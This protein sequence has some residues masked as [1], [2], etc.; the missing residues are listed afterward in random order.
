MWI[1]R[2]IECDTTDVARFDRVVET[3]ATVERRSLHDA[4]PI[5]VDRFENGRLLA[6]LT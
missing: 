2:R 5:P 1:D 6:P 4:Q 3:T